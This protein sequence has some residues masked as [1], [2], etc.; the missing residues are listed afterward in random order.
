LSREYLSK[1]EEERWSSFP[2]PHL[3]GLAHRYHVH[4]YQRIFLYKGVRRILCW[5]V[6]LPII[7]PSISALANSVFLPRTT[8]NA[9]LPKRLS[10]C[11]ACTEGESL[12]FRPGVSFHRASFP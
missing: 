12:L 10:S 8:L 4:A 11:L 1:D 2:A 6:D 7:L 9:A 3:A 5:S